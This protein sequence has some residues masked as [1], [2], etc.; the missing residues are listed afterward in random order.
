MPDRAIPSHT[1]AI[2]RDQV[3]GT[4]RANRA[5]LHERGTRHCYT[6]FSQYYVFTISPILIDLDGLDKVGN[7]STDSLLLQGRPVQWEPGYS[8]AQDW[9]EKQL[10]DSRTYDT[11]STPKFSPDYEAMES[12][13]TKLCGRRVRP[14]V[15]GEVVWP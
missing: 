9:R 13:S 6:T 3:R 2:H 15:R 12:K 14:A 7:H 11:E 5:I 10:A 1:R 8:D 4:L